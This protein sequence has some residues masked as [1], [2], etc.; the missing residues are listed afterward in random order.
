MKH[1]E[2]L[3][4]SRE[5]IS[6]VCSAASEAFG[7]IRTLSAP[8]ERA[9]SEE[10]GRRTSEPSGSLIGGVLANQRDVWEG[11]NTVCALVVYAFRS[12][13]PRFHALQS[14]HDTS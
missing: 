13:S 3:G 6:S 2:R 10:E 12:V 11:R 4:R 14:W 5:Q 8:T 1:L 7:A 9:T